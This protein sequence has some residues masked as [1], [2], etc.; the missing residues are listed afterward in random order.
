MQQMENIVTGNASKLASKS[1]N[2]KKTCFEML[3]LKAVYLRE[4]N[5]VL[6]T[7]GHSIGQSME[8]LASKQ[9]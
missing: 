3:K 8:Y 7:V 9:L 6:R 5:K 2:D 4:C 1:T